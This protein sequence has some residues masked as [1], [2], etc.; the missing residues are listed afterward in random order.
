MLFRKN[1]KHSAEK[2][3][4]MCRKL[5]NI[6]QKDILNIVQKMKYGAEKYE[7]YCRKRLNM[8][9]KIY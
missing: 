8:V 5:L 3:S 9:K 6:V 1:T 7:M 2:Y 4:I